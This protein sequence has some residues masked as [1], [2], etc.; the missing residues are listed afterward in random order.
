M[1]RKREKR[2]MKGIDRMKKWIGIGLIVGLVVY[3]VYGWVTGEKKD[4]KEGIKERVVYERIIE[5]G[6][7]SDLDKLVKKNHAVLV[8]FRADWCGYCKEFEKDLPNLVK[9]KD[10]V[11]V[12]QID[13][14]KYPGVAREFKVNATPTL[15]LYK[16]GILVGKVLGNLPKGSL[17]AWIDSGYLPNLQ[18]EKSNVDIRT[19]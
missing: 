4:N 14:D 7:N 6:D 5:Y 9:A 10:Y 2:G 3:M 11:T 15:Y 8:E 1:R 13:I 12:V 19:N 18:L 16:N 17:M